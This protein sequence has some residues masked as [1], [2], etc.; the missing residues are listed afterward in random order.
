VQFAGISYLAVLAA[1]GAGFVF[2][3]AWYTTLGKQWVAAVGRSEEELRKGGMAKRLVIS[4]IA[5]LFMAV[6]TA[7]VIGHFSPAR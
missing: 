2:G 3:A 1:A 7:G 6:A 5:Q 4:A